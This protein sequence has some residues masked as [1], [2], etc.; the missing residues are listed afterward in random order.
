MIG[1]VNPPPGDPWQKL[2]A[3]RAQAA[4]VRNHATELEQLGLTLSGR[5]LSTVDHADLVSY[6]V[7][8]ALLT[9]QTA[10]V[11]ANWGVGLVTYMETTMLAAGIPLPTR[12]RR[13]SS[14][15][16]SSSGRRCGRVV[17][18]GGHEPARIHV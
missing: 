9:S 17:D 7:W 5:N 6:L 14:P 12:R 11:M 2:A 1:G 15:R 10:Q 16:L 4:M 18:G 13:R 8:I 3:I